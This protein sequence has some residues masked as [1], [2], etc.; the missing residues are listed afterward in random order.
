M[1]KIVGETAPTILKDIYTPLTTKEQWKSIVQRFEPVENISNRIGALDR[2]H[3]GIEKFS[4]IGFI[5]YNYKSY[6][7]VVV[8][9]CCDADGLFTIIE[10]GYAGLNSGRYKL[11]ASVKYWLF[12]SQLNISK[13]IKLPHDKNEDC[14]SLIITM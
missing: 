12:N 8:M 2:K 13:P 4:R 14:L 7:S 1:G 10:T 9:A 3:I 5:D 6:H 11:R